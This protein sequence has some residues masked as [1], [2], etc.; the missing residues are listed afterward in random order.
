MNFRKPL[1]AQ[2]PPAFSVA[3][4][5][6][7]GFTRGQLRNSALTAPFH[8]TRVAAATPLSLELACRA[9]ATRMPPGTAFSHRTAARLHGMPLP[10][11][12]DTLLDVTVPA[13]RRAPRP[14]GVRGHSALLHPTDTVAIANG[15]LTVT[16]V[17]RTC[18]D[19]AGVLALPDLVAAVDSLLWHEEPQTTVTKLA[20][21]IERYPARAGRPALRRA[22]AL[23]SDHSRSRPESLVRVDLAL[24]SLPTPVANFE[25]YLRTARRTVYLD[26][27]YPEYKLELEYH[28]DQHR[29]D[30][31]QWRSDIRR[32]N[33]V[34]DEGWQALQFTGDDLPD[35]PN[36]RRRVERR[37]RMLGWTGQ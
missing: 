22:L 7:R 17:E 8:G 33:D 5:Y 11:F 2:L 34:G 18:C 23:S 31:R 26:L 1:P 19:L 13:P 27:A 4:A 28:G 21:A 9:V 29:T 36:L 25:V 35:L 10:L 20:D 14:A 24:S 30:R 12:A 15:T 3:D 37:L 16:S 32:T 6:T